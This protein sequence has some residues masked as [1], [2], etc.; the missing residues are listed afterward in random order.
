MAAYKQQCLFFHSLDCQTYNPEHIGIT[1]F[2]QRAYKYY[3]AIKESGKC[4]GQKL[5]NPTDADLIRIKDKLLKYFKG[6]DMIQSALSA[7]AGFVA[8]I[9]TL[10]IWGGVK[11]AYYLI[12]LGYEIKEFWEEV[13]KP[14]AKDIAFKIGGIIGRAILIV[15]SILM[16]RRRFKRKMK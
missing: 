8:N 3:N 13:A 14:N 2:A 11:G 4:I 6:T 9:I 10:G 12:S 1:A 5:L 16:G 15:K 7:V